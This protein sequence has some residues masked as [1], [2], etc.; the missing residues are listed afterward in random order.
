MAID[1]NVYRHLFVT[2]YCTSKEGFGIFHFTTFF[3]FKHFVTCHWC[4][5]EKQFLE[6]ILRKNSS[7]SRKYI[8]LNLLFFKGLIFQYGKENS[9]NILNMYLAVK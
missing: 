2:A 7:Y 5:N 1:S 3:G 9:L 8:I 6:E 4:E